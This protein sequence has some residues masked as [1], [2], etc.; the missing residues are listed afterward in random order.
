MKITNNWFGNKIATSLK[1]TENINI[2]VCVWEQ[3][4]YAFEIKSSCPTKVPIKSI[5][6]IVDTLSFP[7]IKNLFRKIVSHSFLISYTQG[8]I[9]LSIQLR[10]LM[11]LKV[12]DYQ[13]NNNRVLKWLWTVQIVQC[14][15]V[16]HYI[17]SC[18]KTF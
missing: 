7:R 11:N 15:L 3:K 5:V 9:T 8:K 13:I 12:Q 16:D 2:L 4:R 17:K 14:R 6:T 1:Q 18:L 10:P